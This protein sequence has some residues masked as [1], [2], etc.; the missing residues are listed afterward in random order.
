[1]RARSARPAQPRPYKPFIIIPLRRDTVN[2]RDNLPA[3]K[4]QGG[5]RGRE[6]QREKG[7]RT[8]EGEIR[9]REGNSRKLQKSTHRG[10]KRQRG[11]KQM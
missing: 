2:Q 3:N 8:A 4:L 1:M 6:K 10:E 9:E 5:G 7:E 11:P